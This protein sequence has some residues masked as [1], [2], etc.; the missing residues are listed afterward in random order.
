MKKR[1]LY[2]INILNGL[3]K[4][5]FMGHTGYQVYG[6]N[7]WPDRGTDTIILVVKSDDT[8]NIAGNDA[9]IQVFAGT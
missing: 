9:S 5:I 2:E 1:N 3:N 7:A 6:L 8:T 4:K